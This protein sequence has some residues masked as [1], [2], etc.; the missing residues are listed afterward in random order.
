M[1]FCS[2]K[3]FQ[4]AADDLVICGK[5]AQKSSNSIKEFGHFPRIQT[6]SDL[7]FLYVCILKTMSQDPAP[8]K[9]FSNYLAFEIEISSLSPRYY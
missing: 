1:K 5:I 9:D 6:G 8:F 2:V 4:G 7:R 3:C